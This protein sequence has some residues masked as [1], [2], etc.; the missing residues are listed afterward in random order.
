MLVNTIVDVSLN[1]PED[2]IVLYYIFYDEDTVQ[3]YVIVNRWRKYFI[4]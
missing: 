4:R 2:H 3:Y 1:P